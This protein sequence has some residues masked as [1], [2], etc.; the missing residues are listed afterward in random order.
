VRRGGL[1][2]DFT[3]TGEYLAEL[4]AKDDERRLLLE[5]NDA[6]VALVASHRRRIDELQRELRFACQRAA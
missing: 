6:L 3:V 4:Y 1:D 2:G 5:Q